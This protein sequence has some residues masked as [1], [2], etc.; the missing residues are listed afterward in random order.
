MESPPRPAR[1]TIAGY[2]LEGRIS[3]KRGDSARQAALVWQHS[4]D[5]D[6][7][8]LSGPLGQKAARL[9]RDAGG[10][11]LVTASRE[12]VAAADWSSLSER[13]L[14]VALPLDDVAR[15][16]TANLAGGARIEHDGAGRPLRALASGWRITYQ[17]YES[18][19]PDA[20]PV[21]I[22]L[23]R[24]DIDVRLKIDAWQLD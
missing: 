1:E 8:E 6:E 20:L 4:V 19:A 3:V 7:I 17:A 24:D 9:T 5:R 10:A 21:L 11:R 16:V 22:E 12:T 18:A 23:R 13:V 15:W 2:A 14:G